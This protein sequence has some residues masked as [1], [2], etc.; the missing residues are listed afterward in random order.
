MTTMLGY[1]GWD[2]GYSR[3][4]KIYKISIAQTKPKTSLLKEVARD[5]NP[6]SVYIFL[7][8][9]GNLHFCNKLTPN[10]WK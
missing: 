1:K 10:C 6:C 8:L 9:K 2:V 7:I 3:R 5:Y 4:G